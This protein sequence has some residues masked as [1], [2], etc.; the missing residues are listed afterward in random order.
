MYVERMLDWAT[1]GDAR[2]APPDAGIF[3]GTSEGG[4]LGR[5]GGDLVDRSQIFRIVGS[6]LST[7]TGANPR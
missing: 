2:G 5:V 7:E 4:D 6:M 1:S 3:G